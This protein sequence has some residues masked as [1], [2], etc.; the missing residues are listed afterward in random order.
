MLKK[1]LSNYT[2]AEIF[3]MV[4]QREFHPFD[5]RDWSAFSGVTS[6][7]PLVAYGDDVTLIIDGSEL[8]LVDNE[9]AQELS[10]SLTSMYRL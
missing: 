9:G 3:A 1:P 6:T 5:S 2:D 4:A 7:N 10:F 8:V